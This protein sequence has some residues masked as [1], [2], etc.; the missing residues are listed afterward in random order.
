MSIESERMKVI[1]K[2]IKLLT[3]ANG[4]NHE[5]EA[6]SAKRMAAE[7]MA[8]HDVK[9]GECKKEEYQINVM[10]L[11]RKNHESNE[12]RVMYIVAS[13]NGCAMYRRNGFKEA[14]YVLV[15]RQADIEVTQYMYEIL[16]RQLSNDSKR[17]SSETKAKYGEC[18]AAT[19]AHYRN[20]WVIG[21]RRKIDELTRMKENKIQEW[22][23][24]PVN[25]SKAAEAWYEND[26]KVTAARATNRNFLSQGIKDGQNASIHTGIGEKSKAKRIAH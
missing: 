8:K 3:L 23:L 11:G 10:G 6:E 4:T 13:F 15:G 19:W 22:G 20:G 2:V 12:H 17:F 18:K 26:H 25:A 16:V 1:E 21:L 7:L 9:I 24:V 14:S 5:A